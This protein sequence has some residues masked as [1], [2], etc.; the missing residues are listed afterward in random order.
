MIKNRVI[1]QFAFLIL[2]LLSFDGKAQLDQSLKIIQED[3]SIEK[4]D[5]YVGLKLS[6]SNATETFLVRT[7]TNKIDLYPNTSNIGKLSF[8]YRF[9]SFSIG[10][11]PGFLP[12]N[13]D[14]EIKGKTKTTS[15]AF[16]LNF[17]H[18][19]QE[20]S[21]TRIR[22]YYLNN[23]RDFDSEWVEGDP[24]V[25]FPDLVYK[26]Y[27]GVTGYSFNPKF[28]VKSLT[29]QTERQLKSAGSF[30]P[31]AA[32]RY[33]I[34]DD[35]T[36]LTSANSSQ[37]SNNFEFAISAG[38]HYTFVIKQNFYFSLG[39]TPGVG[40]NFTKLYTRSQA[41]SIITRSKSPEFRW[42]GR[43]AIGYN[44]DRF[45]AGA[46]LNLGGS[47]FR[48]EHT[49]VINEGYTSFYQVFIGFRLNAPNILR[50]GVDEAL[51]LKSGKF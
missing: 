29:T 44:G 40:Y 11:A 10:F 9:I 51:K 48:Q 6:M 50:E 38:Y 41:E 16:G 21:Y 20:L 33:Y 2:V 22:G 19:F 8:N 34:I 3:G 28:S 7:P 46:I 37:R 23:T 31:L 49:T 45:F 5:N 12:G 15:Y 14:N 42:D 17:R 4:M 18:W 47:S 25:Q 26:K 30:I 24:Y 43:G 1:P 13:G 27:Q 32:Y 35:R 36:P 39:F